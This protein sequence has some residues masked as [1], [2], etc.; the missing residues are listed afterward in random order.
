MNSWGTGL[1]II[2][3]AVLITFLAFL[4]TTPL[5]I[6]ML[7]VVY[8][9]NR[10]NWPIVQQKFVIFGAYTLPILVLFGFVGS[11]SSDMVLFT[12][13]ILAIP[14]AMIYFTTLLPSNKHLID[15]AERD[16]IIDDIS[17]DE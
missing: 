6:L 1:E 8:F 14:A 3:G 5:A 9:I 11:V 17:F 13:F 12:L 16:D 7:V 2:Y 15:D 10:T 4:Y